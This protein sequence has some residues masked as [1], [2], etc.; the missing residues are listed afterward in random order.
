MEYTTNTELVA[1]L[2]DARLASRLVEMD[3]LA[4]SLDEAQSL[5]VEVL[6]KLEAGGQTVSGWK[7]G[8][9][10]GGAYDMMGVGVR[11]FGYL[12][13]RNTIRSGQRLARPDGV[14]LLIEPEVCLELGAPLS[15]ADL[16]PEAC[17]AAVASVKASFEV[18]QSRVKMPGR[19]HLF[20]ADG[21]S[22]WGL[23]IGSGKRSDDAPFKPSVELF[24]DGTLVRA[25]GA[26]LVMDDPFLL[27][28]RLCKG[29]SRYGLRIDAGQ[30]VITGA[31]CRH[32]LDVPG[33][34]Q[35]VFSGLGE[36]SFTL[37]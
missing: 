10:S 21:L 7:V 37:D 6:K 1:R 14:S 4:T 32:P 36:M 25:S 12:L 34:Y 2:A 11:P 29:L 15:G 18:N 20:V 13:S 8:L 26:D 5:Q 35:A 33:E 23:V 30:H 9:T 17:R 28:A 19:N 16:T 3:E 24:H 31:F 27:L 22:N